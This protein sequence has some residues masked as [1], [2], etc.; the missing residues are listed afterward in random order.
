M[1]IQDQAATGKDTP[2]GGSFPVDRS[3]AATSG[4]GLSP[5]PVRRRGPRA[6]FAAVRARWASP[7]SPLLVYAG[8]VLI[9]GG[10]ATIAYTWGEVAG[11]LSVPIQMPYLVSGGF[12]GLGIVAVGITLISV[13]AKRR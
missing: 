7:E 5:P 11:V 10:F 9:V 6:K 4:N 2:V 1:Q 8:V 12:T 13:G 3:A